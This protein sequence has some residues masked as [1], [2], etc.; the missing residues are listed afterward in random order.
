MRYLAHVLTA[1]L[2][3]ALIHFSPAEIQEGKK[4]K[5]EEVNFQNGAILLSGTLFMPNGIGSWPAIAITHG[6]GKDSKQHSGFIS[7]AT[8]LVSEGFAV[9]IYDKRGVGGSTGVYEEAPDLNVPA[10]DLIAAVNY[11]HSRKE[12]DKNKIG[13]YG[14]S[15]GAWVAPLATTICEKISFLIAA[16]GG[17]VSVQEQN[18][19]SQRNEMIKKGYKVV[20]ADSASSFG[21]I[22]YKYLASGDDY[23][24]VNFHYKNSVDKKWFRFFEDMGFSKQLPP[25]SMVKQSMF[26]FF[27]FTSYDPQSTVRSIKVP[28]L[29]I[30][31]GNDESVPSEKSKQ[32]WEDGFKASGK[33]RLLTTSLL[34]NENH[35]DFDRVK[36][37]IIYKESFYRAMLPWLK[38][39]LK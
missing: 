15:Q 32:K 26:N 18:L 28:T 23:E 34:A 13:V 1:L 8:L 2:F 31:A 38:E 25:P 12:V 29:V 36:E 35:Y 14:H 3:F 11:L 7:L 33:D 20:E 9:L 22:L 16:C 6:S 39:T 4:F 17:G 27:K 37:K 19:F 5:T 21:K 10:G 24:Q 30:L